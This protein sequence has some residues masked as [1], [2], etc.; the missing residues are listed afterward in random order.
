MF[1][2]S[3]VLNLQLYRC[4]YQLV[5]Q[6][7]RECDSSPTI[8]FPLSI[9]YVALFTAFSSPY[10]CSLF[11]SFVYL[12]G[13]PWKRQALSLLSLSNIFCVLVFSTSSWCVFSR[14][15]LDAQL[16]QF[17]WV[18]WMCN[19]FTTVLNFQLLLLGIS[20]LLLLFFSQCGCWYT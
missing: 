17:Y 16:H 3:F 11:F 20:F 7:P 14:N 5:K 1:S 6:L 15:N 18:P 9:F 4:R 10:F 13:F 19:V 12:F 2:F 8:L